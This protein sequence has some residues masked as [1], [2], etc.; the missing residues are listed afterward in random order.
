DDDVSAGSPEEALRDDPV[1]WAVCRLLR[2]WMKPV[3][4]LTQPGLE[5]VGVDLRGREVG[6]AE[7]GLNGPQIGSALE[8]MRRERV[9]QHVRTEVTANAGPAPVG[10]ERL[11]EAKAREFLT[12]SA[13][14]E[15]PRPL[16]ALGQARP[17]L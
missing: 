11:P 9:A 15:E 1:G 10:L 16:A 12:F 7:H 8:Q 3:V 14:Q 13:A 5:H 6:M 4:H 17:A 2:S